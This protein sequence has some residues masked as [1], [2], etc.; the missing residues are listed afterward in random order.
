VSV[1]CQVLTSTFPPTKVPAPSSRTWLVVGCLSVTYALEP[2]I[3]KSWPELVVLMVVQA[4][5]LPR[6]YCRFTT[7]VSVLVRLLYTSMRNRNGV[8]ATKGRVEGKS[9]GLIQLALLSE[10]LSLRQRQCAWL[11]LANSWLPVANSSTH[12]ASNR[13]DLMLLW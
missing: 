10:P 11:K 7:P 12:S 3:T 1:N 13:F 8:P 4:P 6:W 5:V 9:C 2:A